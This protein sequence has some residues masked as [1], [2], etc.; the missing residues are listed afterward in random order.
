MDDDILRTR[1]RG[2]L[3]DAEPIR[4][5]QE[6]GRPREEHCRPCMGIIAGG[7]LLV[8]VLLSIDIIAIDKINRRGHRA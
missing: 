1:I 8:M 4:G 6:Y 7:A 2:M 5:E 3:M